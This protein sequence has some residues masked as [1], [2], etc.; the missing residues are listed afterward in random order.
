MELVP[1]PNL[2]RALLASEPELAELQ[3][4]ALLEE[5]E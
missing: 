3:L 4:L 2:R 1:T 5:Q